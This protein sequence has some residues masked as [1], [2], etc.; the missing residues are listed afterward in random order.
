MVRHGT[1]VLHPSDQVRGYVGYCQRFHSAVQDNS[2]EVS[3]CVLFTRDYFTDSYSLP[4]NDKLAADYPCFTT[5][6]QAIREAFPG[7]LTGHLTTPH[8]EFAKAFVEGKYRQERGFVRQIGEQIL[9]PDSS[10]FELLD[11]QRRAFAM[12]R[13]RV[14]DALFSEGTIK[15][16]VILID[17]PPGSG[18]SVLAAKIWAALVT[19]ERLPDGSVVLTTT[20][21]SQTSNWI[22]LFQRAG[23]AH[24]AGGVIKR[25]GG[26]VPVSTHKVGQ[27]RRKYG[28][29]FL[30]DSQAWRDNVDLLRN[31]GV[32]FQDG[33]QDDQYL[34][35]IVDEAHALINPEHTEGPGPVR[36][37]AVA[38]SVGMA[39]HPE[40]ESQHIPARQ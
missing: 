3:G 8:A 24:P 20:S 4:P 31:M 26:Y 29:D 15:K 5:A 13:A 38:R 33:A 11:N 23:G 35:S 40:L 21:T 28:G 18:K 14:E 16:Q 32:P 27:L 22:R 17:G 9:A 19:D 2:A 6:P 1:I 34:V 30:K 7:Y 36:L 12:A 39:H 25:A 37:R 10:P